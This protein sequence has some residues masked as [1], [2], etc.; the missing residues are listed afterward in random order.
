MAAVRKLN[1][2]GFS[3]VAAVE[4]DVTDPGSVHTAREEI[5]NKVSVLDV[6]I[7]NAGINGG[8]NPYTVLAATTDEY[9][10]HSKPIW[11]AQRMLHKPSWICSKIPGAKNR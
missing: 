2:S 3:N 5:G 8:S 11:Q 9:R 4:L 10:M 7:N 6:L 1:E